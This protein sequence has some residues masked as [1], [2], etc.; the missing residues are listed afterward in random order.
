MKNICFSYLFKNKQQGQILVEILI[1]LVGLITLILF[2]IKGI[3][4][5]Y[6][7]NKKN[8]HSIYKE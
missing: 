2:S 5:A 8:Q 6:K 3:E 1:S 4:Q 7:L